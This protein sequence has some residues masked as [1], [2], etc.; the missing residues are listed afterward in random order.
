MSAEAL[1]V[2]QMLSEGKLTVDEADELLA[3]LDKGELPTT[4][5]R[6]ARRADARQDEP[7]ESRRARG[8]TTFQGLTLDQL[9]TLKSVGVKAEYI[10]AMHDAFDQPLDI[11]QLIQLKSV[12]V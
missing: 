7:N 3:A 2:L 5:A 8:S 6:P 9:T 10:S 11:G 4:P 12:G 1:H